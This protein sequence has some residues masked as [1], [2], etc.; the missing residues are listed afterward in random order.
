MRVAGASPSEAEDLA[1]ES[2]ARTLKHWRRVR[3]GSRPEGY[4]YRVAFRLLR[5]R[6]GLPD[7]PLDAD[8]G[9]D[10]R[11]A[12]VEEIVA[13]RLLARAALEAMPPRRRACVVLV[14]YLG[15]T[16]EEAAEVLGTESSTVRKQLLRARRAADPSVTY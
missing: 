8:P 1:Q 7:E 15:F 4:V 6:G 11:D 13:D 12:T 16:S 14:G 2:F 9:S 10:S 5:R 3:M